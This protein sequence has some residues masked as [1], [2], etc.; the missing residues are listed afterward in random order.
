MRTQGTLDRE[1]LQNN[2][3]DTV[4][5]LRE[6]LERLEEKYKSFVTAPLVIPEPDTGGRWTAYVKDMGGEVGPVIV[7]KEL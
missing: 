6:R 4:F 1:K 2:L 7:I 5:E 3:I